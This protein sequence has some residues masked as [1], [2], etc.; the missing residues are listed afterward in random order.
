[1]STLTLLALQ[2][3]S[4][5]ITGGWEYVWAGYGI[6]FAALGWYAFSLWRRNPARAEPSRSPSPSHP[7]SP[8]DQEAR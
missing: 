8:P 3:G 2:V 7:L 1:M 4:G 5:R 6:T